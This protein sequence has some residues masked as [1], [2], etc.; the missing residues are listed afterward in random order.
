MHKWNEIVASSPGSDWAM[1]KNEHVAPPLPEI[2][3][4]ATAMQDVYRLVRL[5]APRVPVDRPPGTV[6][7]GAA[8]AGVLLAAAAV[9][10]GVYWG[11]PDG[12][13]TRAALDEQEEALGR[14]ERQRTPRAGTS[15][16]AADITEP[17]NR[18]L[19]LY[20]YLVALHRASADRE[21]HQYPPDD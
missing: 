4:T 12:T 6:L 9:A 20:R 8:G 17:R 10:H 21:P 1:P 7:G 18:S 16:A 15:V 14:A 5:V 19:A 13:F 11:N 3:G 2:V